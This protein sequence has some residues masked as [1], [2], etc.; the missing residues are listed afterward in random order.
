M[1]N[2]KLFV[3]PA[4]VMALVSCN[5]SN[6]SKAGDTTATQQTANAE[7]EPAITPDPALS[8]ITL[9]SF[10]LQDAKGNS[11]DLAS[12][13]GKTILVNLWASWCPPCRREMP[14]LRNLYKAANPA[15]T[16]FFMVALDD[17]FMKSLNW[18]NGQSLDVPA[19]YPTS[20]LPDLFNVQG[21]PAT[22][23]FDASGKLIKKVEGAEDYD[24]EQYRKLFG[25]KG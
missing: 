13:K 14:S 25:A 24:V 22:F 3:L 5:N 1:F 6:A 11:V 7:A 2:L 9:P 4:L 16:A 20:P 10:Q 17:D 12:F 8:N 18:L 15:T 21:I 19:Y 23:I